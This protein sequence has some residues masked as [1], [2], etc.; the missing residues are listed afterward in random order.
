[1]DHLEARERYPT[2]DTEATVIALHQPFHSSEVAET[3]PATVE[4]EMEPN[5][6][7]E[8]MFLA[9]MEETRV[10]ADTDIIMAA[11]QP[12]FAPEPIYGTCQHVKDA[13]LLR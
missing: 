2:E 3:G 1:L 12:I 7:Y 11:S 13:S 4:M 5:R 8:R 10:H 6:A 9:A